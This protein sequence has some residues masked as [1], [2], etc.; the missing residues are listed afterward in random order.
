LWDSVSKNEL[1]VSDD[2]EKEL[3]IRLKN[4]EEGKSELYTWDEVKNHL[5]SIR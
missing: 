3:D 4:F 2:L 1:E 5:K